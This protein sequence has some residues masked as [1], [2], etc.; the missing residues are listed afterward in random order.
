[1]TFIGEPWPTNSTGMRARGRDGELSGVGVFIVD[2]LGRVQSGI[3]PGNG[4]ADEY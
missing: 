3:D 1:M 2:S 4:S